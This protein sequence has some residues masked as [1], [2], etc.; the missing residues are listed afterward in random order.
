MSPFVW[1]PQVLITD[2]GSVDYL[3]AGMRMDKAAFADEVADAPRQ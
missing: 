1:H 2:P 3:Q